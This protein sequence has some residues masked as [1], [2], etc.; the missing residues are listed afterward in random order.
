MCVCVEGTHVKSTHAGGGDAVEGGRLMTHLNDPICDM[1]ND[2]A[3]AILPLPF[4]E[5]TIVYEFRAFL[6]DF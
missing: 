3:S 4:R 2:P 6:R 5:N 1:I